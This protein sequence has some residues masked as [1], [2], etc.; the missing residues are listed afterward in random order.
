LALKCRNRLNLSSS[1]S[2][3]SGP[4][5]SRPAS[6]SRATSRSTSIPTSAA[7][8]LTVVCAISCSLHALGITPARI[9]LTRMY[10][11]S[12]QSRHVPA[13]LF[14]VGLLID[15]PVRARGHDQITGLLFAHAGYFDEFIDAKIREIIARHYFV[16]CQ[17]CRQLIVHAVNCKQVSGRLRLVAAFNRAD[18]P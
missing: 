9:H 12:R 15:E 18:R 14:C 6:A 16:V 3:S 11:G 7:S 8:C 10:T 4:R 17:R 13:S 5:A 2:K 1:L